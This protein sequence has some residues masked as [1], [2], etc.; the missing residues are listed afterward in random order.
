VIDG[1]K[2]TREVGVGGF[3]TG[4]FEW[5]TNKDENAFVRNGKLYIVPVCFEVFFLGAA[6]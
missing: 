5:T 3:G 2:W 4:G 6:G 1:N